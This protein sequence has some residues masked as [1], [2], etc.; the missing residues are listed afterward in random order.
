M[1][2]SYIKARFMFSFYLGAISEHVRVYLQYS[3]TNESILLS[4]LSRYYL[5]FTRLFSLSP[6]G[7]RDL[8]SRSRVLQVASS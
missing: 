2:P 1:K 3:A 5:T 6:V 8:V 7:S 4:Q